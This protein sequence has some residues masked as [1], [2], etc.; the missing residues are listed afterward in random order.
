MASSDDEHERDGESCDY[1]K[2]FHGSVGVVPGV[3]LQESGSSY[4]SDSSHGWWQTPHST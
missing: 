2:S 4:G 1:G 3:Q